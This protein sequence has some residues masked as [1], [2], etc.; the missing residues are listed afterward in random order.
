MTDAELPDCEEVRIADEMKRASGGADPFAEAVRATRMPMVITNPRLPDN[1]IVFAN[2]SFCALTGYAREEIVGRNCRLLQ[3][4][5]TDPAEVARI[6]EAVRL[7]QA[8][9]VDLR[10]YRKDGE[11]FWNRLLMAPVR[12][13]SGQICFFFASQLDVTMERERL[14]S[15]R[16]ENASL[17]RELAD[18]LRNQ[19]EGEARLRRTT[20]VLNTIL[21]SAPALIY[22]KDREGRMLLANP[23][24]LA[25]IGRP[26]EEVEGRRDSEFLSDT[27]QG[28]I[29]EETDSRIMAQDA[30]REVEEVVSA[31]GADP[32]I[33][34]ST[35]SPMRDSSGGV[36]GL[37]GVSID[38]TERKRTQ[39]ALQ[40][41]NANLEARIAERTRERDR[42]WRLSQ[43]LLLVCDVQGVM[44]AVSPAWTTVLGWREDELI[45]RH[46]SKFIHPD[47]KRATLEAA[48]NI[49]SGAIDQGFENRYLHKDGEYRSISW[50]WVLDDTLIY[51]TGRDLT[52]EK[53]QKAALAEVEGRLMQSQK[54]RPS[55]SLPAASRTTSTTCCRA[56]PEASR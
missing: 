49:T 37:V 48:A 1:P 51:S 38:I 54:M 11:A 41:L 5:D 29:I 21:T 33:W 9:Q 8:I 13:A 3:G 18:R 35:K 50:T 16:G 46:F 30:A 14:N 36:T 47:D 53:Q 19:E 23:R 24:A 56:S 27:E 28:R 31:P 26:W 20:A 7:G 12:D 2:D 15:L 52:A 22:A 40:E 43:N 32:Q 44:V 34:L 55:V 42:A 39:Q 45:G 4:P 10:N 17:L 6:G 25:L